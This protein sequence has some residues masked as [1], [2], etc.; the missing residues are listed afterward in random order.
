MK[1]CQIQTV[2]L[3]F[4]LVLLPTVGQSQKAPISPNAGTPIIVGDGS[5]HIISKDAPFFDLAHS[6]WDTSKKNE[7]HRKGSGAT[8]KYG[9]VSLIG[10][11]GCKNGDWSNPVTIGQPLFD[12]N[13]NKEDKCIV[14]LTI[15]GPTDPKT[16]TLTLQDENG[17]QG[18]VITSSIGLTGI[19]APRDKTGKELFRDTANKITEIVIRTH[20]GGPP[21]GLPLQEVAKNLKYC[22]TNYSSCGVQIE[23]K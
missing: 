15:T 3:T 20:I 19:Y 2:A 6:N 7:Y 1:L 14:E 22:R 9:E 17:K 11:K 5:V 4:L 10:C 18:M 23:Y 21:V 13:F 8:G 16:E 12:F